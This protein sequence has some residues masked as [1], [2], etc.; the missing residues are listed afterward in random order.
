MQVSTSLLPFGQTGMAILGTATLA[1]S[2]RPFSRKHGMLATAG[3]WARVHCNSSA[4][5]ETNMT[6]RWSGDTLCRTRI[7]AGSELVTTS[8]LLVDTT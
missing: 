3:F 5:P 6:V 1:E 8:R 2:D 4:R 7:S